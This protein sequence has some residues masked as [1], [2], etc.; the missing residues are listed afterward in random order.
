MYFHRY[1]DKLIK[2]AEKLS[3]LSHKNI[4]QLIGVVMEENNYGIVLEHIKY[5]AL[6]EFFDARP[7][8]WII[9]ENIIHGVIIGMNYL[10]TR[11]PAVI[12]QDL[13]S[14]NI[15]IGGDFEP[16]VCNFSKFLFPAQ[17]INMLHAIQFVNVI[18]FYA[19][20]L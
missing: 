12:H 15:L 5:G 6:D 11:Q 19:P 3:Q 14:P 16:K 10:H 7:L 1:K 13:K 20:P 2:E 4:V 17:Y 18:S 8:P 9:K